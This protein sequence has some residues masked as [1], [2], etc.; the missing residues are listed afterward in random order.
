LIK[1]F[2]WFIFPSKF[3]L[4]DERFF[5]RQLLIQKKLIFPSRRKKNDCLLYCEEKHVQ[6]CCDCNQFKYLCEGCSKIVH[7]IPINKNHNII[8]TTNDKNLLDKI[9]NNIKEDLIYN[10]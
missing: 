4:V 2:D 7:Q 6:F 8:G 3:L 9:K 5:K 1:L 10:G